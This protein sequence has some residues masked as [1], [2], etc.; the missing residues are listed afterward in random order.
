MSRAIRLF[1]RWT[2]LFFV[3]TVIAV[4]VQVALKQPPNWLTYLPLLPLSLLT[5][6]GMV[7]FFQPY[8]RRRPAPNAN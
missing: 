2:S 6:T 5:L 3:L 8:F 4:T 1:H 7:M